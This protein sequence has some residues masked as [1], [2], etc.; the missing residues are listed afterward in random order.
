[1][2]R[3]EWSPRGLAISGPAFDGPNDD[4][5]RWQDYRRSGADPPRQ[6][7]GHRILDMRVPSITQC[8][9][10]LSPSKSDLGNG[11][12]RDWTA[13]P[14]SK[15]RFCQEGADLEDHSLAAW[16]SARRQASDRPPKTH[17]QSTRAQTRRLHAGTA[18]VLFGYCTR[19]VRGFLYEALLGP[20]NDL[21]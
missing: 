15:E 11:T 2:G 9:V 10:Y 3:Q 5:T 7:G 19:P 21:P 6:A 16:M 17:T 12:F 4:P 20:F 1:M 14:L 8:L 18:K 13:D